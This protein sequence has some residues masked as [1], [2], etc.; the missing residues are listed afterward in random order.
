MRKTLCS[1]VWLLLIHSIV[2][3]QSNSAI[4][5]GKMILA[6]NSSIVNPLY[7]I[8]CGAHNT[9]SF[10]SFAITSG[11]AVQKPLSYFSPTVISNYYVNFSQKE[12]SVERAK[13][14]SLY[15]NAKSVANNGGNSYIY[16]FADWDRDGVF[17]TSLGKKTL[18]GVGID[19]YVGTSYNISV[20]ET[21]EL[22]KTRIRLFYSNTNNS[23]ISPIE[24]LAQSYIYDFVIF[25]KE[26]TPANN[27]V[28]LNVSSNNLSLGAAVI[29]TNATNNESQYEKGSSITVEALPIVSSQMPVK[30]IGWH[31]GVN[32]VSTSAIYEFNIN[33]PSYLVALFETEMATLETPTVSI[34]SN[35]IWYQIKNAQTDS[36]LDRFIAYEAG[37]IPAG[38]TGNLRIEKPVDFSD[39]FLWRLEST[40]DGMVKIINK[41]T[42]KQL[43]ATN[44]NNN[45]PISVSDNG[46]NFFITPS[47][48]ANGSFSIQWNKKSNRMLNGGLQFSLLLYDGGLG[49]GSGW[50]FYRVPASIF[51]TSKTQKVSDAKIYVKNNSINIEILSEGDLINIYDT[52]GKRI[53]STKAKCNNI[54]ENIAAPGVYIVTI[55]TGKELKKLQKIVIN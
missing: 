54:T 48:N 29:K 16:A 34:S 36:R 42:E 37:E 6:N 1:L 45:E 17:E 43:Y 21:A 15:L 19:N 4:D 2:F 44:D 22:G 9:N 25:I 39:K 13:D 52:L 33:K 30:F 32:I 27:L 8:P 14:F 47:G 41:G 46:S 51:S 53:I 11:E 20:P 18:S 10:L 23:S 12:T 50:Y 24:S 28:L 38:Y 31:D 26:K 3:G 49:T 5:L 40:S 55:H 35:P 7:A